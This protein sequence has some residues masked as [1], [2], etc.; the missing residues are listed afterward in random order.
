TQIAQRPFLAPLAQRLLGHPNGGA[1]AVLGHVDRAW[2]T[3]FNWKAQGPIPVDEAAA[4]AAESSKAE[5]ARAEQIEVFE[6]V[7]RRLLE[8]HP[9]GSAMEYVNQRH[10]ELAVEMGG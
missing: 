9:V 10:A 7:L 8:G 2:T 4:D 1:L 5:E 3:S 6:S